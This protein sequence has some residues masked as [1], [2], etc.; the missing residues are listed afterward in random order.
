ME[1]KAFSDLF[2]FS[3]TTVARYFNSSGLMVQAAVNEPR[4]EYDPSTLV[5]LGLKMEPHRQN[6]FTFSQDFTNSIWAKARCTATVSGTAPDGTSTACVITGT[7]GAGDTFMSRNGQTFT[8]GSSYAFSVFAKAGTGTVVSLR[9][10]VDS[11][12][13]AINVNFDLTGNGSFVV[14]SGSATTVAHII[15]LPN[16]W[17]KCCVMATAAAVGGGNWFAIGIGTTTTVAL[18]VWGAQLEVGQW[19]SSY[20]PT[21][22]AAATRSA[23][24]CYVPTMSPWFKNL[25]GTLYSEVLSTAGQAFHAS[26]GVASGAAPRISNWMSS[27]RTASSQVINDAVVT[28]FGASFTAIPQ[29]TVAKQALAFKLNDMQAAYNGTL[30]AFDTAAD[31]PTPTRLTIGSRGTATDAMSGHVRKVTIYPY[32]LSASELQ[33]ITT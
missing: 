20:I 15:K 11:F 18:S 8:A 21:S 19:H 22:S 24:L 29:G 17:F 26:L 2:T 28:V 1:A 25:E 27:T 32:R 14:T 6:I 33:A 4:F 7:G 9:L 16:G 5:P 13:V 31:I 10:P 23:D 12:G 3:R 30:S